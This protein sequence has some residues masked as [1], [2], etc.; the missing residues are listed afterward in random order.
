M[1]ISNSL[2]NKNIDEKYNDLLEYGFSIEIIKKIQEGK[3]SPLLLDDYEK[4]MYSEYI[5]LMN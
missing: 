4:I 3:D 2:E 5:E 1:E